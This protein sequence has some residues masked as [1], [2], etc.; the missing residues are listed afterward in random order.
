MRPLLPMKRRLPKAP[1]GDP[2]FAPLEDPRMYW[3]VQRARLSK[4]VREGAQ[5]LGVPVECGLLRLWQ[6][7]LPGAAW[8]ERIGLPRRAVE[9]TLGDKL[10][11]HVNPNNLVRATHWQGWP[12]KYRP[13]S[14]AFIWDGEWDLRRGDL[15]TSSRAR[16]IADIDAHRDDLAQ[17]EAFAKYMARL[18]AGKP[19]SSHQQGILLD[20]EARIL[21]FLRVYLSFMD[22]MAARGFDS[23]RGKDMLGVAVTREGRLLKINRGLHRLA[24]AQHLGL[25]SVPVMVKAVHRQWWERVTQGTVGHVAWQRTCGE[26]PT[27]IPEMEAGPLDPIES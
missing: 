2:A 13:T 3:P 1:A 23:T 12:Y 4:T 26:L 22:D 27:C 21:T 9:L 10:V 15:R 24:M 16:F 17:S 5:S 8:V 18:K 20:S 7:N 11:L 14:S 25:P 19:W 6:H